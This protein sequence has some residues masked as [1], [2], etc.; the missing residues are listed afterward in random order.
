MLTCSNVDNSQQYDHSLF[1]SL[2]SCHHIFH[3]T[4]LTSL[5]PNY[6]DITLTKL[7]WR[8]LHQIILASLQPNYPVSKTQYCDIEHF[9]TSLPC[10]S[11]GA[12]HQT[13]SSAG[14]P[15]TT[16]PCTPP[17]ICCGPDCHDIQPCLPSDRLHCALS[18]AAW[19]DSLEPVQN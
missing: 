16:E 2:Q 7:S 17:G 12:T 1:H 18:N 14:S 13:S 3:Q 19:H 10:P 5:P 11:P 9:I 8:H 15:T 6:P 4:I